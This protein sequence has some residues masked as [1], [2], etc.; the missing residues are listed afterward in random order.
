MNMDM[1]TKMN[2][3]YGY[4]IMYEYEV[5]IECGYGYKYNIIL[6]MDTNTNMSMGTRY[7]MLFVP[8]CL[9]ITLVSGNYKREEGGKGMKNLKIFFLGVEKGYEKFKI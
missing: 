6:D 1:N 4:S 8:Y 7:R 5:N 9:S 3:G 2:I